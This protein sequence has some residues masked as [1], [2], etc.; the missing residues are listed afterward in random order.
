MKYEFT[1]EELEQYYEKSAERIDIDSYY[2]PDLFAKHNV[3]R[4]LRNEDG[5]GVVVGLTEIGDVVSYVIEDG[6]KIPLHG[7]L[8]Y[9]GIDVYDLVNACLKENRF[10]F[11]ECAYLLL[12][13][14]LPSWEQLNEFNS[15]LAYHRTLPEGF[16]RDI[17]MKAPS[18]NIMNRLAYSMLAAYSYDKNPEDTSVKNLF[19]K[20]VEIISR[21][22]I[23]AAYSYQAKSHYHLGNSLFIHKPQAHLSTAEN[24]LYLSRPNCEYTPLEA[25]TLDTAL[26]LHAEHGGGNNSTFTSH[27]V[28]STGTDIYSCISAALCSLKGQKHGGANLKVMEMMD[29]IKHNVKNWNSES[30]IRD[31]LVKILNKEAYDRSGLIY[32]IGHAVY[33][34]SD[35]RCVL[36]KKKA[37]KLADEKGRMEEYELYDK[38]ER[39]G[40]EVFKEIK[41]S[42]KAM[43]ANVDFYS[44][45]VYNMLNIPVDLYTALFAIARVAGLC[46][47]IIEEVINGGRIIRPAYINVKGTVEYVPID[48]RI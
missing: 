3:K 41:K 23:L 43:C 21:F 39:L 35:P 29:E 27:V 2:S 19:R 14:E 15:V 25:S 38:V 44:G 6:K 40:I 32:G 17:I 30:E 28:A 12:F 11:E 48:K 37:K 20:S 4:G 33:T 5:T 24:I 22:P 16:V 9:R 47:H 1:P 8:F 45:F 10:G 7:R 26:I 18:A 34:L 42:D 46:A 13:G 31:Y 36:L